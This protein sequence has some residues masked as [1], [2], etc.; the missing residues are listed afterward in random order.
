MKNV[1]LDLAIIRREIKEVEC[2]RSY[3]RDMRIVTTAADLGPAK[4]I[5]VYLLCT[6]R[7]TIKL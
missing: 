7:I 1:A 4:E 2:D 3:V 5:C 6:T